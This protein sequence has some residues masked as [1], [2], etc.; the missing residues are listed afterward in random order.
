MGRTFRDLVIVVEK[1]LLLKE[2]LHIGSAAKL[3]LWKCR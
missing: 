2:E 3:I 1:Q